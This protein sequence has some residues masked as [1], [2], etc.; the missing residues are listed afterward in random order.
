MASDAVINLVVNATGADARLAVQL[1]GIVND[2]ERNAPAIN[3]NVTI[4]NSTVNHLATSLRDVQSASR[5][6]DGDGSRL[7]RT[8]ASIGSTAAGIAGTAAKMGLIASIGASAIPVV[9]GLVAGLASIAP[10]GA[11]AVTGFVALKA[12]TLTLKLGLT[13]VSD[14][15]KAVFDPDADPAK[16]AE[17]LEKLSP[18]ARAFVGELQKM[19]PALDALRLDVQDRFFKNLDTTLGRV[20]KSAFPQLRTTA[21]DFADTFNRM[22]QGVGTSALQLSENGTLGKALSSGASAFARLEKVPGQVLTAVGNLAAAGGPLLNRFTGALA[23]VATSITDKLGKAAESGGLERAVSAAGDVLSQLGRIASNVGSILANVFEAAGGAGDG[24]FGSIERVTGALEDITSTQNFKDTLQ[25][26]IGVGQTLAANVLPLVATAFG[27]LGPVIQELALP[28][29]KLL[30]TLGPVFQDI[31]TAL[32]PVL[33]AVAD[34]VGALFDALGPVI[35]IIGQMVVELLP[36]LAPL[37]DAV[38]RIFQA[39]APVIA[40]LAATWADIFTPAVEQLIPLIIL[41]SDAFAQ[42]VETM[43]PLAVELLPLLARVMFAIVPIATQV[44]TIMLPLIAI[45]LEAALAVV[46]RVVPAIISFI[47][48]GQRLGASL[49]A[50]ANGALR[51]IVLPALQAVAAFMQGDSTRAAQLAQQAIVNMAKGIALA[52]LQLVPAALLAISRFTAAIVTGAVNANVRF[53]GIIGQ[54]LAAVGARLAS[55]PGIALRVLGGLGGLLVGAGRA[56]IGGFIS[57]MLSRLGD[58]ASAASRVVG[59]AAKYFPHSP[60]EKGPFSGRGWTL[61][62]GRA[63][64]DDFARGVL[65][66]TP[67]LT[68]AIDTALGLAARLPFSDGGASGVSTLSNSFT[69]VFARTGPLVNVYLGNELING[70]IDV[71]VDQAL[72]A[73]DRQAAQ[74]TRF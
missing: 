59:A 3:L 29:E 62:S 33:F 61:Y 8:L 73:R 45:F 22:A 26:L 43:A 60:A 38:T 2:A 70:H 35:E 42:Y 15:L 19:R 63:V 7:S 67:A 17:A 72:Q 74:G 66:R 16:V 40:E 30:N 28:V 54:M 68:S 69:G 1:Q 65:Q 21:Q 52:L 18:A 31:L 55:L 58:I 41:L 13:G 27:I 50:L 12:A 37:L 5:D 47:D 53:L 64:V 57:G 23:R 4:D 25:A 10:A 51:G 36:V 56:L 24:L 39:L 46:S 6:A 34:A 48:F 71:Q 9:A 32:G 14:A 44:L 11:A 49:S 20:G